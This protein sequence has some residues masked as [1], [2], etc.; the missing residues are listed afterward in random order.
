MK[1]YQ[2]CSHFSSIL[3]LLFLSFL[4]FS[5]ESAKQ[6]ENTYSVQIKPTFLSVDESPNNAKNWDPVN[7][8][9]FDHKPDVYYEIWMGQDRLFESES[10]KDDFKPKWDKVEPFYIPDTKP[11]AE[12]TIKFYDYDKKMG[13]KTGRFYNDDDLIGE[14]K[15]TIDELRKKAQSFDTLRFGN[16]KACVFA[17]PVMK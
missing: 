14:L 10:I 13:V 9:S 2:Y 8:F 7:M 5:C 1:L 3:F 15:I 16:I 11:N 17:E 6:P 12:L 4:T